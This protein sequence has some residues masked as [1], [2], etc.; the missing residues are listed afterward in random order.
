MLIRKLFTLFLASH[1]ASWM[2]CSSFEMASEGKPTGFVSLTF[3]DGYICHYETVLPLLEKYGLSATF[4]VT[5]SLLGEPGYLSEEQ[6]IDLSKKGNEIASHGVT[7]R[8][9]MQLPKKEM[10]QEFKESK[11]ALECLI[12]ATVK[13]FAPPFGFYNATTLQYIKKYYQ[14]N[15]GIVPGK[16]VMSN[17]NPYVLRAHVV[18]HSTTLAELQEWI[19]ETIDTKKWLILVYHHI[20]DSD[21]LVSINSSALEG[22]LQAIQDSGLAVKTVQETLSQIQ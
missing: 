18:F 14:S 9:H 16:N 17:L 15:R 11:H 2:F 10:E 19:D 1:F 5:S 12:H 4:Y 8:N 20:D 22:H 21:G 7:H 3:D 6:V 13:D